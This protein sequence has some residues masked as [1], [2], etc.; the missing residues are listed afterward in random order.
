MSMGADL[1]IWFGEWVVVVFMSVQHDLGHAVP[2][3]DL[4]LRETDNFLRFSE[5]SLPSFFIHRLSIALWPSSIPQVIV[6]C[7]SLSLRNTLGRACGRF[8]RKTRWK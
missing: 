8:L 6:A 7:F 3:G 1:H 4:F 2:R 5:D